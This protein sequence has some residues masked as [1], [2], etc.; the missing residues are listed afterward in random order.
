[1][2]FC[3]VFVAV[4]PSL[5][6]VSVGNQFIISD[7]RFELDKNQKLVTEYVCMKHKNWRTLMRIPI[8]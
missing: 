2:V 8:H 3:C 6:E 7:E 1:M 4:K 5:K